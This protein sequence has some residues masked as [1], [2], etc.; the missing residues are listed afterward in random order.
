MTKNQ[1]L[2]W[3]IYNWFSNGVF[4]SLPRCK[5]LLSGVCMTWGTAL[6]KT[7]WRMSQ[8]GSRNGSL[9]KCGIVTFPRSHKEIIPLAN[10]ITVYDDDYNLVL[11]LL[12]YCFYYCYYYHT[13]LLFFGHIELLSSIGGFRF[14]D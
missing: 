11:L 10:N 1:C 2:P 14:F 7:N 8:S 12:S 9:F 5:S 13:I 6:A 3:R 4:P